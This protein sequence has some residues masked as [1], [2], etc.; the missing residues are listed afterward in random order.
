VVLKKPQLFVA[1]E[2]CWINAEFGK[3]SVG[4]VVAER[5]GRV[6]DESMGQKTQRNCQKD[7]APVHVRTAPAFSSGLH[8][9]KGGFKFRAFDVPVRNQARR[10][11]PC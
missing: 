9:T 2:E 4:E 11:T 3:R 6:P 8:R 10:L 7:A 5:E 1:R